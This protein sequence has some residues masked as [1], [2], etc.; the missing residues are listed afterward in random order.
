MTF[1]AVVGQRS[2][3][4]VAVV[5]TRHRVCR[6]RCGAGPGLVGFH[7]DR[8]AA[9]NPARL[10]ARAS[11]ATSL[12]NN[13]DPTGYRKWL[14]QRGVV[15]GLEY[16]NDMLSNVRGG[17]AA[18]H[19][20]PGQAARHPDGRSSTSCWASNGLT[21]LRQRLPD[22]QHRPH[23]PRLRRRPQHHRRDR[24]G[25]DDAAFGAVAR[26]EFAGGKASLQG[27][28][29]HGGLRVFLQR[30]QHHVPAERLADD[31]GGE[32]AERRGGLSAVHAR[33]PPARS[34]RS[35]MCRCCSP[36]STAIRPGRG[37][38]TSSFATATDSISASAIRPSSSA[39]RSSSATWARRTRACHH[40]EARRLGALR[41]V[42]RPALRHRR[43]A[44]RRSGGLGRGAP[45]PRQ[46]RASMR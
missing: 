3:C 5:T 20:R 40:V 1:A 38:A 2:C 30:A 35:R 18:R 9:R 44:A 32:P 46:R 27:R 19:H 13:G 26:T 7:R 12:P 34:I 29:A 33:R 39:R 41:A 31:R 6:R 16:T 10:S 42:Q 45:A 43:H 23:P 24:G 11:I 14:G 15:Y 22:S 17:T 37:P 21:L 25:A 36:C 28:P 8:R 4:A